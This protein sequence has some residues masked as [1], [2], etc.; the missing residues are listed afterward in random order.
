[1]TAAE[2]AGLRIEPL[3]LAGFKNESDATAFSDLWKLTSPHEELILITDVSFADPG[4]TFLNQ[5]IDLSGIFG[6]LSTP[7]GR[8]C[9]L[10]WRRDHRI[11]ES[12]YDG[13]HSSRWSATNNKE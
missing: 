4:D 11:S 6:K 1:M 3:G 2:A 9:F 13:A 10:W 7:N 12:S 5:S 8:A